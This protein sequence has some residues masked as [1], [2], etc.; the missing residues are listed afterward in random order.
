MTKR[1]FLIGHT[2]PINGVVPLTGGNILSWASDRT[3]RLWSQNG[4]TLM[5]YAGDAPMI[6]CVVMDNGKKAIVGDSQGRLLLLRIVD[7]V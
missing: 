4:K 1:R 3:L 7:G 5:I 2:D 6:C